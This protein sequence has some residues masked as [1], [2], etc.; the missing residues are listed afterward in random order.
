MNEDLIYYLDS[1]N[2]WWWLCI[3][4]ILEKKI[5]AMMHDNH[6]HAEFHQIY[7]YIIAN[8]YIWNLSQCLK[9]YIT[10]CFKCLHYQTARHASYE[11]LQLIIELLISFHIITADFIFRFSKTSADLDAVITIICKFFKKMK[12][13]SSKK[14]WTAT[15]WVKVYFIHIIDWS[16]SII[17]IE[18]RNLK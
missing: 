12:F 11:A 1:V 17:W 8:L 15:E 16:I 2:M 18:D 4:K 10:H 5:F 13:I 6:Y 14:I 9:Q 3:S 7:S